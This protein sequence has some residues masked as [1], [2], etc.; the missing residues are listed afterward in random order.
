MAKNYYFDD[1]KEF[2]E[3]IEEV[4]QLSNADETIVATVFT[5][6]IYW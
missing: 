4:R 1:L 6:I 5:G 3:K 2:S